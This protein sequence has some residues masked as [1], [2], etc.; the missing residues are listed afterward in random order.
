MV[1]RPKEINYTMAWECVFNIDGQKESITF[2]TDDFETVYAEYLSMKLVHN[3]VVFVSHEMK[4]K[5]RML[6][7]PEMLKSEK[8]QIPGDII[9]AESIQK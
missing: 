3:V 2:L 6:V 4:S 8:L 9:D 1:M 7:S 5:A